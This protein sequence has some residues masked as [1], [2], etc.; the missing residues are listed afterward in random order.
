HLDVVAGSD[1]S[2][3]CDDPAATP[4]SPT[5]A[6]PAGFEC[7]GTCLAAGSVVTTRGCDVTPGSTLVCP[8]GQRCIQILPDIARAQ[9][10]ST[11]PGTP[12]TQSF[13]AVIGVT[14]TTTTTTTTTTTPTTT[15]TTPTTAPPPPPPAINPRRPARAAGP[16][17]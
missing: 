11:V 15:P 4:C 3:R 12:P 10:T 6:C 17:R 14:P 9:D 2:F 13:P 1:I 16:P 5:L 7:V 8:S